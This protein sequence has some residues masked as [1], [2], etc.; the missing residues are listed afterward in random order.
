ML[1]RKRMCSRIPQIMSRV[2]AVMAGR[3]FCSTS[4]VS[5]CGS[6]ISSRVTIQGPSAVK[7]SK[8]LRMFRVFCRLRPHG[9]RWLMSQQIV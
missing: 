5:A 8:P 9:S 4:M 1:L 7:V 3:P 2:W 6:A